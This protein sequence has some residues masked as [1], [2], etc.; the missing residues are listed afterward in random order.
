MDATN[1]EKQK[2]ERTAETA[3]VRGGREMKDQ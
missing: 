2:N 1:E 3:M